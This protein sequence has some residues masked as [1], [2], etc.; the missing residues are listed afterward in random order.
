MTRSNPQRRFLWIS[1]GVSLLG[2]AMILAPELLDID[3]FSGGGAL[4]FLGIFLIPVGLFV[5]LLFRRRAQVLDRLFAEK[6]LLAHWTYAPGE[7]ETYAHKDHRFRSSNAKKIFFLIA[8]FSVL[9]SLVFLLVDFESG[10]F[11]ALVLAVVV[12][13][14]AGVAKLSVW[15]PQRR[16]AEG[17]GELLLSAEGLWLAGELHTWTVGGARLEE[18]AYAPG[19]TTILSFTYSAPNNGGPQYYTVLVPIPRGEEGQ[20][21]AIL[22]FFQQ[23]GQLRPRKG[24]RG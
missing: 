16:N 5:A 11:V 18:V 12:L 14:M 9:F 23:P 6:D 19:D 22:A 24:K 2:V 7:W 15:L 13:L 8:F 17:P 10:R 3:I 21:K 1:L 20:A 4:I